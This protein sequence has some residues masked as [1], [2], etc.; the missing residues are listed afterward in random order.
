MNL[1]FVYWKPGNKGRNWRTRVYV[2]DWGWWEW[3][4][5]TPWAALKDFWERSITK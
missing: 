4:W 5:Y 3:T 1:G 2:K